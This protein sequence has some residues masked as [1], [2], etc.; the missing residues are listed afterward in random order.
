MKYVTFSSDLLPHHHCVHCVEASVQEL[1]T[2]VAQSRWTSISLI[3]PPLSS[4]DT[5]NVRPDAGT[6]TGLAATISPRRV[7]VKLSS[8]KVRCIDLV[9]HSERSTV[10][11]P[12]MGK[13]ESERSNR[14]FS[15]LK[16]IQINQSFYF[17]PNNKTIVIFIVET[18]G[19]LPVLMTYPAFKNCGTLTW[20]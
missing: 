19:G 4:A 8:V 3:G 10:T 17:T 20:R 13:G 14:K 5:E 1:I 12:R 18:Y 9:S 11:T 15:Q 6:Y 2:W 16:K 7:T